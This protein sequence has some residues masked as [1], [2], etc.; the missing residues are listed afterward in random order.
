MKQLILI[1]CLFLSFCVSA[2]IHRWV[3]ENGK[4]HF[5]DKPP[6]NVESSV[7][8]VRINTYE[9]PKIVNLSSELQKKDKVVM[10]SASWC[11]YCK[12]A[13]AYF[14]KNKIAFK[15]YNIEKSKKG[16]R[17]YDALGG[18]GVPVI[19]VGNKRLNGFSVAS[20]ESMYKTN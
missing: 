11:G 4:V 5:T 1:T 10:Y 15:E 20:F 19:L 14:K 16:K 17:E 13:K 2:E 6:A 8:K 9:S 7:I 12:K 3:D 18:R